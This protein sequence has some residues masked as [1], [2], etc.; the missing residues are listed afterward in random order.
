MKNILLSG[1]ITSVL[2][3]GFTGCVGSKEVKPMSIQT[4][5]SKSLSISAKYKDNIS[6]EDIT[7]EDFKQGLIDTI[8]RDRKY[9]QLKFYDCNEYKHCSMQGRKVSLDNNMNIYYLKGVGYSPKARKNKKEH[10]DLFDINSKEAVRSLAH[11]KFPYKIS[12]TKNNFKLDTTYPKAYSNLHFGKLVLADYPQLD[13]TDK[14]KAD[15]LRSF[16]NLKNVS[17]NR[18]HSI[19]GEVNSKYDKKS[20]EAN[21][22]RL[23][24][25]FNTIGIIHPTFINS[26]DKKYFRSLM[27]KDP[28]MVSYNKALYPISYKIYDYRNGSKVKYTLDLNYKLN[29]NGT[30][31]I[32]N[33]DLINIKKEIAKIV[34]D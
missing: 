26:L 25:K 11:F 8:N 21:F 1:A 22:H 4:N 30:S 32:S 28:Y 34:N 31:T 7:L 5:A 6:K 2:A 29:S 14:L 12:G 23:L 10:L 19:Y 18:T 15:A 24:H 16:N 13:T 33:T 20:I 17:I 27:K 3:I 9:K